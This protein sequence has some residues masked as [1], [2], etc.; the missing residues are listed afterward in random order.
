MSLK[1][2]E[3]SNLEKLLIE[4][5]SFILDNKSCINFLTNSNNFQKIIKNELLIL[6]YFLIKNNSDKKIVNA[7][8]DKYNNICSK[9]TLSLKDELSIKSEEEM[10]DYANYL[11]VYVKNILHFDI[12]EAIKEPNK[13]ND[14]KFTAPVDGAPNSNFKNQGV[15]EG[16]DWENMFNQNLESINPYILRDA[17]DRIRTKIENDEICIFK[18]KP[19]HIKV[20]KTIY[21]I[22][23]FSFSFVLLCL[24]IVG[25]IVA[26]KP[27]GA[28]TQSGDNIIFGFWTPVFLLIFSLCFGYFG[29]INVAAYFQAWKRHK[30]PSQNAIY[31]VITWY[32]G[33][34][35]IFSIF[36]AVYMMWPVMGNG[37]KTI[38]QY[39][40]LYGD[41]YDD[42]T[43][44]C[45]T[46]MMI[47][48]SLLLFISFCALIIG[49]ILIT[50]KPKQDQEAIKKLLFQ[51]IAD[52]SKQQ[53]SSLKEQPINLTPDKDNSPSESDKSSDSKVKN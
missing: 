20:L 48:D 45:V 3:S 19:K 8:V 38:F 35:M 52:I 13:V 42:L 25:F 4:Q 47:I 21:S 44:V 15:V 49:I 26:K 33:F 41:R 17:Q 32:V 31:S 30:K 12:L 28:Q 9:N 10:L 50:T 27:T 16:E 40:S 37:A 29:F 24:S 53:N 43:K 34:S 36:F 1:N 51:E 7:M 5:V 22:L 6:N 11:K 46:I 2:E 18:S 23:M 39:L 14:L